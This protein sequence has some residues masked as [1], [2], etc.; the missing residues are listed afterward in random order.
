MR[1]PGYEGCTIRIGLHKYL[2]QACNYEMVTSLGNLTASQENQQNPG[3]WN[4]YPAA[5]ESF[6]GIS[7][8]Q[9]LEIRS[10]AS[11]MKTEGILAGFRV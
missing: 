1:L 8:N 5:V 10:A 6:Y 7:Q 9:S 11:E 4:L 3:F 2:S